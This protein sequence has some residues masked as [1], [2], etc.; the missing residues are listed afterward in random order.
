MEWSASHTGRL[1]PPPPGTPLNANS[2]GGSPGPVPNTSDK[3]F[4]LLELITFL[5]IIFRHVF[6]FKNVS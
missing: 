5:G 1:P 4:Y 2:T 3:D 6:L